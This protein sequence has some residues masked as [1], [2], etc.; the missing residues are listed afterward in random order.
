M[1]REFEQ[2]PEV[3][4]KLFRPKRIC[5]GLGWTGKEQWTICLWRS[6]WRRLGLQVGKFSRLGKRWRRRRL[7]RT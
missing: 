4:F 5:E 2:Y 6:Q 7:G 3:W 1:D